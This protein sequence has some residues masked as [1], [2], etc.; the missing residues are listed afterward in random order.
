MPACEDRPVSFIPDPQ[1]WLQPQVRLHLGLKI[2]K[3]GASAKASL[4]PVSQQTFIITFY[5]HSCFIS[6]KQDGNLISPSVNNPPESLSDTWKF[7]SPSEWSW[8]ALF[9]DAFRHLFLWNVEDAA[10][11]TG[12][13][14][15]KYS[16]PLQS[17]PGDT[18]HI[19]MLHCWLDASSL[20]EVSACW[21]IR[22]LQPHKSFCDWKR[23]WTLSQ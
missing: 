19:C 9:E 18:C 4:F 8:S 17:L 21:P 16:F 7:S 12:C 14:S 11:H 23:D 1:T 13:Y 3:K 5:A 10:W 20:P 2:K 15:K 22:L 6:E